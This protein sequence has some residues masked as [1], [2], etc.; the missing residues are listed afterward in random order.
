MAKDIS[1]QMLCALGENLASAHLLAHNW[2]TANINRS[3]TNFKGIDL[4]C[5]KDPNSVEVVGVQVKTAYVNNSAM[6]GISC[7]IAANKSELQKHIVGPWIFVHI[8][9]LVPLDVDYYILSRT[10]IINLLYETHKWYLY[11]YKRQPSKSLIDS[12]AALKIKWLQGL[13]TNSTLANFPFKNPYP[14]NIFLN[15]WNNLWI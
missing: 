12:P 6:C 14:G 11:E 8:K 2:P 1:P 9:N 10:Q 4:Y 3:I 5:Q 7:G 13:D 15:N